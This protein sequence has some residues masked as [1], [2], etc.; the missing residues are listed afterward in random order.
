MTRVSSSSSFPANS[1]RKTSG[2][3]AAP[4]RAPKRTY[5]IARA[6][7]SSGY[8]SA[9]AVRANSTAPFIAPTPTNPRITSGALSTT[10]PS[11]VSKQPSMPT[12][13]PPAITGTRPKRSIRRPAGSAASGAGGQ[14]DRGPEA[15][16]RLDPGDED[17][18]NRGNG[19]GQLQDAREQNEAE[20]EQCG[21]ASDRIGDRL[22]RQFNQAPHTPLPRAGYDPKSVWGARANRA[23]RAAESAADPKNLIWV[24]PAEEGRVSDRVVVVVAGG[25]AP[26]PEVMRAV[27]AG[28]CRHRRG[29]WARAHTCFRPHRCDR[30]R[31]LRLGCTRDGR[32]RR[33]RG[34]S[35]RAPPGR[36]GRH[37]SRARA[38]RGHGAS[39]ATGR[40]SRGDR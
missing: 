14:E 28:C 1:G 26:D 10:H 39:S 6:F 31:R 17:E 8:M 15:E 29:R 18:R 11:A 13:K 36:Q 38:R 22:D 12:T 40:G 21:V 27:P 24:I 16:D 35:H 33:G 30:C 20:T 34:S 19:D 23:E 32:S 3:S 5:E 9:A 2:P 25:E 7:F 4:K 37:R